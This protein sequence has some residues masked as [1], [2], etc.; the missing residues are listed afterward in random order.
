MSE[1]GEFALFL[2]VGLG[3]MAVFLGP[4]GRA[5]AR[6]LEGRHRANEQYVVDLEAR[7]MDLDASL[8]RTAAQLENRLDFAER[9]LAQRSDSVLPPA[10]E[11]R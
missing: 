7:I 9:L 8:D 6:R 4:L 10:P 5:L 2:A 1:A 11:A 3:L